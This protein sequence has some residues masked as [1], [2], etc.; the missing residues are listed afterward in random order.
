M[1]ETTKRLGELIFGSLQGTLTEDEMQELAAWLRQ[2]PENRRL[3]ETLTAP[4][5]ME[6]GLQDIYEAAASKARVLEHLREAIAATP[7]GNMPR[8]AVRPLRRRLA[9]AAAAVLLLAVAYRLLL[10]VKKAP[11]RQAISAAAKDID[12]GRNGAILTLA[13]GSTV[14]LDSAANGLIATQGGAQVTLQNGQLAYRDDGGGETAVAYNTMTTPRGRQFQ[15]QLPDGTKVWLNAASSLTYPTRFTGRE[16]NVR[17]TGEAYFEVAK[18]AQQPFRVQVAPETAIEVKGTHFNVNAYADE[19]EIR[20]TLL[21]GAI[22][23]R[24][25]AQQRQLQPGQQAS[26]RD[27]DISIAAVDVEEAVAWKNGLFIFSNT[28]IRTVMRQLSRWYD[29]TVV[30]EGP[31]TNRQLTGEVYRSYTLQQALS[32]L[33]AADLHFRISG[34]QLTVMP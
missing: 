5:H 7:H 14:L 13:N 25:G 30:V 9:Y 28:D 19:P 20:A 1:I 34:R 3:Y 33:Q 2:S 8:R 16:R 4:E 21:E 11:P 22:S 6:A 15:L 32:V 29:I 26:L 27:N 31:V 18:N 10:P 17:I 12:P 23:I 24:R